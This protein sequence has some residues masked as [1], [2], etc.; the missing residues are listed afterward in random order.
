MLGI[1]SPS[2]V[3]RDQ[4]GQYIP[5]GM[6]A[7]IDDAMGYASKAM[8]E[9]GDTLAAHTPDIAFDATGT[10]STTRT[11]GITSDWTATFT[12]D[13][14]TVGTPLTKADMLDC[15]RIVMS[16]GVTLH[17]NSRG[18]EVMAGKLAKPM[19]YELEKASALGR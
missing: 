7:G 18:G 15:L 11:P 17:L 5:Q 1:H 14:Q 8:D 6:A 13:R 4:I 2:R 16:D 10:I 12:H 9:L 3:F 19:A